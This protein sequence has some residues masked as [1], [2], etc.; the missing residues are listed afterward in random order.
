[1]PAPDPAPPLERLVEGLRL[2]TATDGLLEVI[3][4]YEAEVAR[5]V[6]ARLGDRAPAVSSPAV[7]YCL[8][9]QV[10]VPSL[11]T[12]V[13]HER[14][15]PGYP[16]DRALF[17]MDVF[18]AD[19]TDASGLALSPVAPEHRP[20]VQAGLS[21][22]A[23]V[24]AL[25][26][27]ATMLT[28]ACTHDVTAVTS[29][30]PRFGSATHSLHI[31]RTLVINPALPSPGLLAEALLH[32]AVHSLLYMLE[33][34]RPGTLAPAVNPMGTS[35]WSGRRLDAWT[36]IQASFVWFALVAFWTRV[37]AVRPEPLAVERARH[38]AGGFR[39]RQIVPA[40]AL[41]PGMAWC[42]AT[43]RRL[44]EERAG[45]LQPCC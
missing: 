3:T 45:A 19:V 40:S 21:L 38:A 6:A 44:A 24:L 23:A 43:M 7:A 34:S 5:R 10:D 12:V 2:G 11:R 1:M 27:E 30:R 18:T 14:A 26:P 15:N 31:G 37:A 9:M 41:T 20:E 32:E 13:D 33:F 39:A 42:L 17:A 8:Q 22:A 35:P 4:L 29:D 36:L 25:V 28:A 16:H